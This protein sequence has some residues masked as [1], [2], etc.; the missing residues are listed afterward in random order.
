MVF[1]IDLHWFTLW[2]P[3]FLYAEIHF[4]IFKAFS[5]Y[6][7]REPEIVADVPHRIGPGKPL[8]VVLIVKDAHLYPIYLLSVHLEAFADLHSRLTLQKSYEGL[9]IDNNFWYDMFEWDGSD[10]WRG[11]FQV[12]VKIV[13]EL[14]GKR[15][16]CVNDNYT[17]TSHAP[18]EVFFDAH[19]LPRQRGWVF[20]DLHTHSHLSNDQVEFGA[21][22]QVSRTMARAM[23]LDFIASTDHSYDLDD[24]LDTFLINDPELPKWHLLWQE[25]ERLNKEDRSFVIIPGEEVSAGNALQQNVH[26]LVLNNRHFF[27]GYGDSAEKWLQTRAQHSIADILSQ[28]EPNALSF[29]SHPDVAPPLLQK[30]LLRRSVWTDADYRLKGLDGVQFWNGDKEQFLRYGLKAWITL[31][32][33]GYALTLVAGNDAHGNFNRFRQIGTPHVSMRE[34]HNEVF[35]TVRTAVYTGADFSLDTVIEALRHGRVVVTDGP[36]ATFR[37]RQDS[38]T[39]DMGETMPDDPTTLSVEAISTPTYGKFVS[40][41]VIIGDVTQKHETRRPLVSQS[42]GSFQLSIEKEMG[43]LPAFG[44]IRLQAVTQMQDRLFHC[45]TNPLYIKRA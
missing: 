34:H 32:L 36:F 40:L 29:A 44:Y 45:F 5:R 6:Y 12:N 2:L 3:V 37:A 26:Y 28:L 1:D 7:K 21:P 22:W 41:D 20:G 31:L 11:E 42:S 30:L 17:L 24:R 8:P 38:Q 10:T 33:D 35:G 43:E 9:K 14:R 25:V 19:A 18:F 13:Y 27:P 15:K 23:E 39:Y 4:R 16:T